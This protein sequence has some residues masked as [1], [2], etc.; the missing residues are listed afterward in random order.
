MSESVCDVVV[1]CDICGK[2]QGCPD[3]RDDCVLNEWN[4]E[5]G[6]HVA[7]EEGEI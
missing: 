1:T 5:T 6:C 2:P 3:E 4:G 7:C